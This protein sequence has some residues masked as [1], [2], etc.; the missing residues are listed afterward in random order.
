MSFRKWKNDQVELTDPRAMRALAHPVRL[1]LLAA[2]GPGPRTATECAEL[3]GESPS[4]CSY[5]LRSLARW[6]LVERAEGRN[7]KER[8]WRKVKGGLNWQT[9]TDPEAARALSA[10]FLGR[11]W[12]RLR[13]YLAEPPASWPEPMYSQTTLKLTP[14]EAEEL[15]LRLFDVLE[16]YFPK[17]RP[18][19]PEGAQDIW[20]VSFGVPYAP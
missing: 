4:S 11:D 13:D 1:A 10:M 16:P 8:P 9:G 5:H 17:N 15:S 3:V 14:A 19:P 2:L 6:G 12:E 7:G 20:F 18:D